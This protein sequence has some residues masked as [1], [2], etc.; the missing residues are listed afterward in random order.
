MSH[1]GTSL[2]HSSLDTSPEFYSASIHLLEPI[3][4]YTEFAFEHVWLSV[5]PS[6]F[7]VNVKFVSWGAEKAQ[8]TERRS[9][10]GSQFKRA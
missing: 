2:P 3:T 1:F 6:G 8:G 7:G 4:G 10:P 9:W 5:N